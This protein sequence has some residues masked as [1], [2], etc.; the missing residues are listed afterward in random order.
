[1][2]SFLLLF[3]SLYLSFFISLSHTLSFFLL[4]ILQLF[5]RSPRT[6]FRIEQMYQHRLQS[7]AALIQAHVRGLIQRR[8]FMAM[9]AA[10]I[11]IF[12]YP[13]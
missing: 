10:G 2:L 11:F 1:M 7:L 9:K 6:L 4:S 5:I 3:L 8:S 12:I 13:K